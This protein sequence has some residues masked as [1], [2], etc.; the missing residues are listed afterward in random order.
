MSSDFGIKI[1]NC[2]HGHFSTAKVIYSDCLEHF[3][4]LEKGALIN[5]SSLS[6]SDALTSG[7][8]NRLKKSYESSAELNDVMDSVEISD[9]GLISVID[10]SE[11]LNL[12]NDFGANCI[13]ETEYACNGI[14]RELMQII[15]ENEGGIYADVAL[16]WLEGP[17]ETS[18]WQYSKVVDKNLNWAARYRYIDGHDDFLIKL[19]TLREAYDL[20]SIVN[21]GNQSSPR[22]IAL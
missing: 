16:R 6:S 22:A 15:I 8:L 17:M 3:R 11:V 9:E 21:I 7:E 5:E 12:K 20:K 13:L 18:G 10:F 19:M 4:R 14:A 1:K 2:I